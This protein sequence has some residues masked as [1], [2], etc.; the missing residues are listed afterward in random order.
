MDSGGNDSKEGNNGSAVPE[1]LHGKVTFTTPGVDDGKVQKKF[2]CDGEGK[3]PSVKIEEAPSKTE[4]YALTLTDP[5]APG[6]TFTHWIIWNIPTGKEVPSGL[7]KSKK[8]M[9]GARQGLNSNRKVGYTPPC[10]PAGH[11]PH[12]YVF[13]AYALSSELDVDGGAKKK[14]VVEAIEDK[15]V[16]RGRTTGTYG[17]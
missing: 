10:P 13:T 3:Q 11:D 12:R 9:D 8:V 1:D 2:T 6:D 15:A 4:F 5:D 17:R 14:D 7:P 16:G